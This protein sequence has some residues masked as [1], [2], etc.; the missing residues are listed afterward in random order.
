MANVKLIFRGTNNFTMANLECFL[1]SKN[2]IYIDIYF[3][4]NVYGN[5]RF[6]T[7]DIPTAVRLVKTL[8]TEIAKAKG[9]SNG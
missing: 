8:K 1:N 7:L 2:E 4:N 5:S 6:I 9:G 3:D